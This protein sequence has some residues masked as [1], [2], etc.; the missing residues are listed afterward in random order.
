MGQDPKEIWNTPD[1]CPE[2]GVEI[3]YVP[4]AGSRCPEGE[5]AYNQVVAECGRFRTF[6]LGFGQNPRYCHYQVELLHVE[7]SATTCDWHII[8]NYMYSSNSPTTPYAAKFATELGG[9]GIG[10]DVKY[11]EIAESNLQSG[12]SCRNRKKS[13]NFSL[14]K[15]TTLLYVVFFSLDNPPHIQHLVDSLEHLFC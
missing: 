12:C 8:Y 2:R 3:C 5:T 15:N 14:L 10:Q 7:Q 13:I 9:M 6:D 4:W 1:D 11:E